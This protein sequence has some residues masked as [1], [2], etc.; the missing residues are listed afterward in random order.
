MVALRNILIVG[1]GVSGLTLATALARHG[2][3]VDIAEAKRD[4]SVLGV[5]FTITGPTLRAFAAIGVRERCIAAGFGFD[6]STICNERGEPIGEVAM[7]RV[8]GPDRPA[9][10]G[11]LRPA[12][13]A[14]LS[15]AAR[16]GGA[17]IRL[18]LTVATL[19]QDEDAVAVEFSDGTG[20]R[21][22]LV[23]GA[24]GFRSAVRALAF[25]DAP[26]LRFTGQIVWRA[27]LRRPPEVRSLYQ[28]FGRNGKPGFVPCPDERMLL[29]YTQ[30]MEGRARL[31]E[32]RLPALLR[33]A[34][35]GFGGLLADVRA[36]ITDE[37]AVSY[38]NMDSILVPPPWYRHRIVLI[39]DAAHVPGPYLSSGAGMAVEDAV[40]LAERLADSA[41]IAEALASFMARR[42]ERCRMVVENSLQL[43]AWERDPTAPGADSAGLMARSWAAL[44]QPI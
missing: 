21:Y 13:H 43:A 5:G 25:A 30:N 35:G 38:R 26:A 39:G 28:F 2:A 7:P 29:F 24:D 16:A 31:P 44:A 23:V 8:N 4:W 3:A 37:T 40:V 33:Q 34:L 20:G 17:R 42:F 12:L 19:R 22:D 9:S 11:I 15:D 6:R 36:Q 41:S 1:G 14:I 27:M 10:V 18:G 32:A